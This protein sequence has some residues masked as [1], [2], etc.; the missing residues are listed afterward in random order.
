[1]RD[2]LKYTLACQCVKVEALA[3]NSILNC[4]ERR[5]PSS[6]NIHLQ[7]NISLTISCSLNLGT[8]PVKKKPA[9]IL[10]H[11]LILPGLH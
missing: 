4:G 8:G 9:K 2:R 5:A 1:M 10:W 7:K 11:R 3:Y 6:K